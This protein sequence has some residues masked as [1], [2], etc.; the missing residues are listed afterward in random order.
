MVSR[1]GNGVFEPFWNRLHIDS[2]QITAAETV[3]VEERGS[4]YDRTGALRD[5]TPNH[6]FRLCCR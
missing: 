6:L 3:G 4:F 5:M 2:V 1:F